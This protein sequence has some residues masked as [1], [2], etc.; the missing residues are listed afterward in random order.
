M[1]FLKAVFIGLSSAADPYDPEWD[2]PPS[3]GKF[4]YT[5]VFTNHQGI[6]MVNLEIGS[7]HQPMNLW[8]STYEHKMSVVKYDSDI[9]IDVPH[10]YNP[11]LSTSA[12][13]VSASSGQEEVMNLNEEST[14]NAVTLT[15]N[16]IEDTITVGFGND[17][18]TSF[19]SI[20][21]GIDGSKNQK[22]A[23]KTDGF[24]GLAPFNKA[25]AVTDRSFLYLLK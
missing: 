9:S 5:D 14:L 24:M 1:N 10:K 21:L 19:R 20:F 13:Y 22:F 3:D 23:S 4:F 17:I 8:I 2:L 6:H 18:Y 12:V 7:T 11:W 25:T 15:G 16:E